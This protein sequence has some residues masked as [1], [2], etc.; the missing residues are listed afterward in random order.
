MNNVKKKSIKWSILLLGV[1]ILFGTVFYTHI[2]QNKAKSLD[3]KNQ[4]IL[5]SISP[6]ADQITIDSNKIITPPK[7]MTLCI[8]DSNGNILFKAGNIILFPALNQKLLEQSSLHNKD[9]FFIRDSNL[10]KRIV[11]FLKT[12]ALHRIVC[13]VYHPNILDEQTKPIRIGMIAVLLVIIVL[14]FPWLHKGNTEV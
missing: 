10:Q 6:L 9:R 14:L 7:E 11:S 1:L 8:L 13:L 3:V 4:T 5:Q 2:R 12:P